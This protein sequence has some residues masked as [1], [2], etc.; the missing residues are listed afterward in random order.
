MTFPAGKE[1]SVE[2]DYAT[3]FQFEPWRTSGSL[4]TSFRKRGVP[5]LKL[6]PA[7]L[8]LLR[9]KF[10]FRN[11]RYVLRTDSQWHKRI[12]TCRVELALTFADR[13]NNLRR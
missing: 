12:S 8:K 13:G 9:E 7:E 3:D 2:V 11:F 1:T 6:P 5:D 10:Q 4:H